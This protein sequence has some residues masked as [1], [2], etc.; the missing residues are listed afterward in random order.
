[1]TMCAYPKSSNYEALHE[2]KTLRVHVL[3]RARGNIFHDTNL[4]VSNAAK[5]LATY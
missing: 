1:M 5:Y 4:F 3:M 2:M